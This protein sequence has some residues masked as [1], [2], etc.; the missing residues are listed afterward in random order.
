[1]WLESMDEGSLLCG[2]AD[3]ALKVCCKIK[4]IDEFNNAGENST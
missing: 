4:F 3:D 2:G 1:M